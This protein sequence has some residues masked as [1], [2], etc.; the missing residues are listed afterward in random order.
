MMMPTMTMGIPVTGR[1]TAL[2]YTIIII[3][4]HRS[5]LCRTFLNRNIFVLVLIFPV[6]IPSIRSLFLIPIL[7]I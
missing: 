6:R 1:E 4:Y 3:L 5:L 7:I 2:G